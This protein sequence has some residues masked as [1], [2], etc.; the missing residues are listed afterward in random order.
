MRRGRVPEALELCGLR[1]QAGTSWH[2]MIIIMMVCVSSSSSSCSGSS[3]SSSAPGRRLLASISDFPPPHLTPLH[4]DLRHQTPPP[5][6]VG[7]FPRSR[8]HR[9]GMINSTHVESY[10]YIY[11]YIYIYIYRERERCIYIYNV[12]MNK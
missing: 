5:L 10:V 12:H 6:A 11:I 3:S 9:A 8:A 4:P 1:H 7:S 2:Q